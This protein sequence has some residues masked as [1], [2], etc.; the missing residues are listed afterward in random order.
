[1]EFTTF[2]IVKKLGINRNT[3]QQYLDRGLI[4]PSIQ[5]STGKGTKNIFS[6]HD[7]YRIMFFLKLHAGGYSQKVASAYSKP[8]RFDKVGDNEDDIQWVVIHSY[9]VTGE[10]RTG[11]NYRY[12]KSPFGK[13]VKSEPD[14]YMIIEESN[15]HMLCPGDDF[16]TV[17]LLQIKKFVDSKIS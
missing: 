4:E 9:T 3:L 15:L 14:S 1:M 6:L 10:K 5:K 17:N 8:I 12:G 11:F 13:D 16:H 2:Q 7:L